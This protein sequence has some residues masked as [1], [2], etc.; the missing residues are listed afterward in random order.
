MKADPAIRLIGVNREGHASSIASGDAGD[1]ASYL[2][3]SADLT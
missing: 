1:D 2:M 3:V